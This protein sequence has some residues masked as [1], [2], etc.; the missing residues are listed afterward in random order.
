MIQPW[1]QCNDTYTM[2]TIAIPNVDFANSPISVI[3]QQNIFL[4][5]QNLIQNILNSQGYPVA[6]IVFTTAAT[7]IPDTININCM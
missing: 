5:T 6:N 3:N 4:S 7:P 1:R 2:L